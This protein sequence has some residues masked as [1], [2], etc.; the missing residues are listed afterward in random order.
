MKEKIVI[1][2]CET[3]SSNM[4]HTFV[5]SQAFFIIV[6]KELREYFANISLSL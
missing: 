3:L 2:M 4:V 6:L 1:K 5:I